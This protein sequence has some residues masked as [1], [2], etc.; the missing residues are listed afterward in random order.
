M[1]RNRWLVWSVGIILAVIILASFMS[2]DDTV[3]IRA[4][5]VQ[6]GTIR[7]LISTNG[8]VEPVENF[9]A[10]APIGTVV[11]RVLIHEGD[12]VKKGQLLVVLNDA[13]ARDQSAR[14]M[15]QVRGSQ[16]DISA[17]QTG[18]TQEE[19][20]TAQSELSKAQTG[21]DQAQRNLDALK[22]LQQSGAA[23]SGEVIAAQNE[24]A[25]YDSDVKL[26]QQKLKD[27]YSKPEVAKVE[28][29]R[30]QAKAA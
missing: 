29:Q 19:V 4:A 15:A 14:A 22:K 17:L 10:H 5:K 2:K 27:R 30:D 13:E 16:A 8:K 18:G 21:R 12:H 26:L 11:K 23:S 7:S 28:A 9:E 3:P 20:L 24:L 6:R 25:R 1:A